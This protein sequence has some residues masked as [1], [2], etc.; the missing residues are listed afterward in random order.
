LLKRRLVTIHQRQIDFRCARK[1]W[2]ERQGRLNTPHCLI[3]SNDKRFL[4]SNFY[5]R[6]GL[7]INDLRQKVA[8]ST[9]ESKGEKE[10][11]AQQDEQP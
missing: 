2:G 3:K 6:N 4:F 1:L 8:L 11:R 10:R 9:N 5:A 7:S